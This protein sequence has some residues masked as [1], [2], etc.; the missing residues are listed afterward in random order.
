MGGRRGMVDGLSALLRRRDVRWLPRLHV[1]VVGARR[2]RR[3]PPARRR[4]RPQAPE[5]EVSRPAMRPFLSFYGAKWR[6][7]PWYG[8]PTHDVV[9]EPFAGSAG[10]S[11]YYGVRRA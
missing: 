7:A 5:A 11:A 8:P 2:A 3:P 6:S 4:R 1:G 9:V 10:Y